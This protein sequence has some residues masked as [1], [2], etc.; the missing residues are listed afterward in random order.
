MGRCRELQ[1]RRLR[2]QERAFANVGHYLSAY[3]LV[4][5]VEDEPSAATMLAKGL[6][7]EAYIELVDADVSG[8]KFIIRLPFANGK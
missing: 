6:R 1:A 3:L 2:S 8:T 5:L 7:E 4:T